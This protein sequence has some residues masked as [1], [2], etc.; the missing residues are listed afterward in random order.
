MFGKSKK[1]YILE[2]FVCN[3]AKH[4]RGGTLGQQGWDEQGV[5]IGGFWVD[6]KDIYQK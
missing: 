4:W 3:L 6:G 5:G 2:V 1:T